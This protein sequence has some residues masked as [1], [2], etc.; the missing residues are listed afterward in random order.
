MIEGTCQ[1]NINN[2]N[3]NKD[4]R[5]TCYVTIFSLFKQSTRTTRGLF[6][7]MKLTVIGYLHCHFEEI[8]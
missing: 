2:I 8:H 6:C 4:Q 7:T 3:K 1:K 5:Q